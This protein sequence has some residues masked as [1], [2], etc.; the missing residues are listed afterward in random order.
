[1]SPRSNRT[2]GV[3]AAGRNGWLLLLVLALVWWVRTAP[4]KLRAI[5]SRAERTAVSEALA[6]IRPESG[7]AGP[8]TAR[9]LEADPAVAARREELIEIFRGS[10]TFVAPDGVRHPYL[11]GYDSYAWLRF[12]RNRLEHGSPCDAVVDGRCRDQLAIAPW[13]TEI[14]WGRSPY[15]AAIAAVHRVRS[16]WSPGV[17]LSS[18]AFQLQVIL[19]LLGVL[20]AFFLGHR[21]GGSAGGVTAALAA[22]LNLNYLFRSFGADNDAWNVVLLLFI[23]AALMI[24]VSTANLYKTLLYVLMIAVLGVVWVASWIGW[25]YGGLLVGTV[26]AAHVA[27]PVVRRP[28]A[29]TLRRSL[30]LLAAC[31]LAAV[32]GIA[33]SG[34]SLSSALRLPLDLLAVFTGDAGA[35]SALQWPDVFATVTELRQRSLEQIVDS[36]GG[37]V[38]FALAYLGLMLVCLPAAGWRWRE[39]TLLATGG[40]AAAALFAAGS[41]E[42]PI[43]LLSILGVPVVAALGVKLLAGRD[44]GPPPPAAGRP[45]LS[46]AILMAVWCLSTLLLSVWGERFLMFFALPWSITLGAAAGHLYGWLAAFLKERGAVARRLGHAALAAG[47]TLGWLALTR[48][49]IAAAPSYLPAIGSANVAA[50]ED[51]RTGTAEDAIVTDLWERGYWVKYFARRRVHVDGG[52]T[53]THVPY[54]VGRFYA[55]ADE[56]ESVGILRMLN[57][58][59][60]ASPLPEGKRGA[61]YR[62]QAAG[63]TPAEALRTLDALIGLDREPAADLLRRQGLSAAAAEAVLARTHCQPPESMVLTGNE[64][65]LKTHAW[66]T[67]A[68]QDPLA[69]P[70]PPRKDPLFYPRWRRCRSA[71]SEASELYCA[72]G[73]GDV[74]LHD[75]FPLD[76]ERPE[77]ARLHR[78]GNFEA[79]L[80][81]GLVLLAEDGRV[82]AVELEGARFPGLGVLVDLRSR[83]V[84]PGRSDLLR[85]TMARLTLI[86]DYQ[87][88]YFE[89]V[90]A[91]G[92]FRGETV[93]LWR[94]RRW[95]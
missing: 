42:R 69:H 91:H 68:R 7:S 53:R 78:Q 34:Y 15:V 60:D 8:A 33:F 73:R 76:V 95:Q 26:M 75:V 79:T 94:V 2:F 36:L 16:L 74:H 41:P 86:E 18:S 56:R 22:S 85:S 30:V 90:A 43:V 59:S 82:R 63:K 28:S 46:A 87:S 24:A 6:A 49:G 13:G 50:F 54:W 39:F 83:R 89:L 52:T 62:L 21:L 55:A 48:D 31:C 92:D 40:L 45:T 1:M 10:K 29:A 58:G 81:P 20:P 71:P 84:L 44:D 17:P 4:L 64:R 14:K 12:A 25:V 38:V 37:R 61:L 23:Q 72:L 47:L 93:K 51:I 88:P 66:Y 70:G 35:G 67:L 65:L 19:G 77:S 27:V 9:E 57:C 80:R 3:L 32:A 11:G 5:D